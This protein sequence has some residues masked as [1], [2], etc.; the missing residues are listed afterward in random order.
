VLHLVGH[1]VCINTENDARNHEPKTMLIL[2]GYKVCIS[3]ALQLSKLFVSVMKNQLDA[4][5]ILN[6]FHHS[7]STCFRRIY[8]PSSGGI[9]CICTANG[10]CYM[11]KLT[12]CWPSCWSYYTD[13]LRRTVNKTLRYNERYISENLQFCEDPPSTA[14][15]SKNCVCLIGTDLMKT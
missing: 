13:I 10:T 11:F 3:A 14:F 12:G 4:L 5:F 6:L 2:K 15:H 8:C 7:T 9:H 1:F